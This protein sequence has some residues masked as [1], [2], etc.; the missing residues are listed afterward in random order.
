MIWPSPA[1]SRNYTA[2]TATMGSEGSLVSHQLRER[3]CTP[4]A[5][6]TPP[7]TSTQVS[8][9]LHD[10]PAWN[11]H[12]ATLIRETKMRDF[13]QALDLLIRIGEIA[14][15]EAHHPDLTLFA[16]NNVRIE[17]YTH[18]IGGLSENDFILAA[19]IEPLINP[20]QS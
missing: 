15:R 19:K 8:G 1:L 7:L 14:E 5:K 10:L 2:S 13:R 4:C 20:D 16:W 12:E 6:G 11:V 9:L 18:S 17:L 3:S